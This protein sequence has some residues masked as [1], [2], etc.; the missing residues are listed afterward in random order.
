MKKI[1][2]K[3]SFK[4]INFKELFLF[5]SDLILELGLS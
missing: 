3:I 1:K 2:P 5:F 4:N